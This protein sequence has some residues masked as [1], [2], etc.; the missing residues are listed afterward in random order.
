[1][2]ERV[3]IAEVIAHVKAALEYLHRLKPFRGQEELIR[4]AEQYLAQLLELAHHHEST[5]LPL[6]EAP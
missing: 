3:V 2:V 6:E 4:E 1:M 5:T